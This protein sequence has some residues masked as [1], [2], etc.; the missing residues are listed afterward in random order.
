MWLPIVT[1]LS[2]RCRR[3]ELAVTDTISRSVYPTE[4]V[5]VTFKLYELYYSSIHYCNRDIV[6]CLHITTLTTTQETEL[7][8]GLQET[9]SAIG[10]YGLNWLLVHKIVYIGLDLFDLFENTIEVGFMRRSVVE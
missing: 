1:V 8:P 4:M 6:R 5:V 3:Y 10:I 7:E 9:A 2:C